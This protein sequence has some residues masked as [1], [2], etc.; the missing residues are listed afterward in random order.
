MNEIVDR[1]TW[2]R[3]RAELLEREKAHTRERAALAAA[4]RA[5]PRVALQQDYVFTG[6]N[7]DVTLSE[8]FKD[9]SQPVK[10]V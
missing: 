3:A 2:L 1:D 10:L 6:A 5:L 8:L 9:R 7:V 4:R